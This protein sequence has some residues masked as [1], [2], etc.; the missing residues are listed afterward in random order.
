MKGGEETAL[1][2]IVSAQK[3]GARAHGQA[4]GAV[5]QMDGLEVIWT[6][7]GE[8]FPSCFYEAEMRT[9]TI[10]DTTGIIH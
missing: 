6:L 5:S 7:A 4:V 3:L 1:L 10:V 9:T 2:F 8:S